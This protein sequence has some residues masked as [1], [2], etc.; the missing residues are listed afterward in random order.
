MKKRELEAENAV[1]RK[2]ADALVNINEALRDQNT[3]LRDTLWNKR[4]R[5]AYEADVITSSLRM[6]SQLIEEIDTALGM[7]RPGK[8][9]A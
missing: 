9:S 7:S 6:I 3:A 2:G 4:D 8:P 1:L 5:L